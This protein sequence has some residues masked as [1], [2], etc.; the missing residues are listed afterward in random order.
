MVVLPLPVGPAH[1][2]MPNGERTIWSYWV[3]VSRG[4]PELAQLVQRPALVQDPHHAL[5]AEHGGHRRDPDV[6]APAVDLGGELAVL[7]LA[8]L[9]DVHVGQDLDPADQGARHGDGQAEHVV[10]GAVDAEPDPQ[11]A[12][13]RLQVDVRGP[14]PQRLGDAAW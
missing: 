5:L 12:V 2:T 14:V 10:E 13:A 6:D 11:L 3:W 8:A 7:G 1:S 4:M 9:D